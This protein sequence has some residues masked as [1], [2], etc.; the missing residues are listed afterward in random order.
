MN[1]YFSKK[2]NT[3]FDVAVDKVINGLK[4][5]GFSVITNID[6]DKKLKGNLNV[7]FRKYK[8]V[9]ACNPAYAYKAL[10]VEDKIGVVLPCNFIIQEL[11]SNLI[12]VAAINPVA[13]MSLIDNSKLMEIALEIQQKLKTVISKL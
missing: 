3:T 13:S 7:D 6:M 5:E 9:G 11:K 2:V 8:I 1:Y 12:E 10:L 4:D